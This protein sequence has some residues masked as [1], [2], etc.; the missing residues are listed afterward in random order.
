MLK[1]YTR[2]LYA[3][4]SFRF[5]QHDTSSVVIHTIDYQAGKARR[6]N[7]IVQC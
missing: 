1:Q 6:V 4:V 5:S 2:V 7:G 3:S